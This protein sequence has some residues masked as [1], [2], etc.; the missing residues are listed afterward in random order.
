MNPASPAGKPRVRACE[1]VG[2]HRLWKGQRRSK[3]THE[4]S[5]MSE[6][7]T[8]LI[9]P[10]PASYCSPVEGDVFAHSGGPAPRWGG[11]APIL[12]DV[13]LSW[14]SPE[15][16]AVATSPG[17]C[18]G[19]EGRSIRGPLYR[20][21]TTDTLLLLAADGWYVAAPARPSRRAVTIAV[22]A[23]KD[24]AKVLGGLLAEEVAEAVRIHREGGS[25]YRARLPWETEPTTYPA[26]EPVDGE[27]EVFRRRSD[28][29]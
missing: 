10:I 5:T 24:G 28:D 19:S 14:L 20:A 12:M 18:W 23:L 11:Y 27:V 2:A 26:A 7:L 21:H 1:T 8:R 15:I 25:T 17:T 3:W 22:E 4:E 6:I 29:E 9:G 16:L 13:P